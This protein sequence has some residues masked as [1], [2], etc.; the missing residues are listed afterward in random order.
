MKEKRVVHCWE[1][2]PQTEDGCHTTCMLP[3]G[4]Q[5]A[6]EWTRDDQLGITFTSIGASIGYQ[7]ETKK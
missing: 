2:G 1:D 4:H 7:K 3:D 6:H 5:E